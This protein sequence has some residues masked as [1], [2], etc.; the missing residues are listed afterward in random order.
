MN[1]SCVDRSFQITSSKDASPQVNSTMPLLAP[2]ATDRVSDG[3]LRSQSTTMT[4]PPLRAICSPNANATVDFPSLG[5]AEVTPMTL[6]D[7]D[8]LSNSIA[9]LID[10]TPSEKREKG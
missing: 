10:L 8:L 6:H 9:S 3:F 5:I 4:A 1:A 7:L 2:G